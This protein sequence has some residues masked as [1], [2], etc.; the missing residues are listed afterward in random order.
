MRERWGREKGER[1]SERD[2]GTIKD[3]ENGKDVDGERKRG[4]KDT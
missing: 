1:G 3:R 4:D 2:E